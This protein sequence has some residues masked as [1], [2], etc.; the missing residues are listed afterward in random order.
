MSIFDYIL[1]AIG[2]WGVLACLGGFAFSFAASRLKRADYRE[3]VV[4]A[5]YPPPVPPARPRPEPC[6]CESPLYLEG[7]QLDAKFYGV[8]ADGGLR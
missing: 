7:Y 4:F 5:T 1:V 2:A 8:L 6:D 3:P